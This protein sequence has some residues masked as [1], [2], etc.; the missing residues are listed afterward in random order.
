MRTVRWWVLVA[1][2]SA[3]SLG[4]IGC[5][6]EPVATE[7]SVNLTVVG[8]T[9]YIPTPAQVMVAGTDG[10][11]FTNTIPNPPLNNARSGSAPSYTLTGAF[12]DNESND[13]SGASAFNCNIGWFAVETTGGCALTSGGAVKATR[14]G[15]FAGGK[16]WGDSEIS[17]QA[18][19]DAASFMFSGAYRY[20]ITFKG[21]MT[22]AASRYVGTFRKSGSTYSGFTSLFR[23]GT[24][25]APTASVGDSWVIE[26]G[27]NWG[28]FIANALREE[29]GNC[30]T[31]DTVADPITALAESGE[32]L[33][34]DATGG[35]TSWQTVDGVVRGVNAQRWALM[36]NS[37]GTQYL[38]GAEDNWLKIKGENAGYA[39]SDYNDAMLVIE[40]LEEELP[41]ASGRFTGGG[42]WTDN[43][44]GVGKVTLGF[45][46]H[47]DN[48]LTNN[49]QINW[50]GYKWHLTKNSLDD[51]SCTKPGEPR[52]P[53]AP[54][55]VINAKALGRLFDPAS[56]KWTEGVQI[57]F[58]LV[59]NSEP[60]AR[61]DAPN[62]QVSIRFIGGLA[63]SGVR[64][65]S[66][67]NFGLVDIK[68]GNI[69]AH[70]D[71]PHGENWNQT[72]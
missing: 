28:L 49:L 25:G 65:S 54:V 23:I 56:K 68:G 69:Q 21:A 36:V 24:G 8:A 41:A 39:D 30:D 64:A 71:Q 40:P 46:V 47:C 52:P 17:G 61:K 70:Y 37:A 59:D 3:G 10:G 31:Y 6:T 63:S 7:P 29:Y 60:S 44:T 18:G 51:I 58:T 5:S 45:T 55:N 19:K 72:P 43:G 15:G 13:Y 9:T 27:A 53:R 66:L 57:E 67:P 48:R 16:Y 32:V 35:F 42:V 38:A 33:C 50:G 14:F 1:G 20:R 12:W 4:A 26:K 2:I 11:A 22:A 34:S 62:D